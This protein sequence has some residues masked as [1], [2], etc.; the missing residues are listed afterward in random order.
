MFQRR[1]SELFINTGVLH[2]ISAT[3]AA[4]FV[5]M[6]GNYEGVAFGFL[7]LGV[8]GVIWISVIWSTMKT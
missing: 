3:T 5:V 7:V 1:V 4:Q 2:I 8:S 6:V